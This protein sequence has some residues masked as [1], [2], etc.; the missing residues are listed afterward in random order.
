MAEFIESGV[1]ELRESSD[2][3]LVTLLVGGYAG[4]D[5]VESDLDAIGA[6]SIERIGSMSLRVEIEEAR[7][8]ELCN[9]DTVASV[10][11]DSND[12]YPQGESNLESRPVSM[13]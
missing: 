6:A 3:E 2:D 8:D 7:V 9:L 12:V 4:L 10:E 13:M 11:F 1:D 5:E